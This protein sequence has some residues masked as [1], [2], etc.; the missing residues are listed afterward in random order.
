M[1]AQDAA[2]SEVHSTMLSLEQSSSET[3][4]ANAALRNKHSNA[5]LVQ[6]TNAALIQL[7]SAQQD[8]INNLT[9]QI[10]SLLVS[11]VTQMHLNQSKMLSQRTRSIRTLLDERPDHGSSM[12]DKPSQHPPQVLKSSNV[13]LYH[14]RDHEKTSTKARS[15]IS[16]TQNVKNLC[17]GLTDREDLDVAVCLLRDNADLGYSG[18]TLAG[19]YLYTLE[20]LQAAMLEELIPAI[21]VTNKCLSLI[22]LRMSGQLKS[23]ITEF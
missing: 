17:R 2:T 14:G 4:Q 21:E 20:S 19:Q 23:H 18:V 10:A 7:V 13:S 16:D 6:N 15:F 9:E 3:L 5:A 22:R 1:R 12:A 8:S 11:I